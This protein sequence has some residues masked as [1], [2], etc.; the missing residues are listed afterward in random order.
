ML[1]GAIENKRGTERGEG[2][3][4]GLEVTICFLYPFN[5]LHS[6]TIQSPP[7]GAPCILLGLEDQPISKAQGH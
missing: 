7:M 3:C 4:H 6:L 2:E 1:E 5:P